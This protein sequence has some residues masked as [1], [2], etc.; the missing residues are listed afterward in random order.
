MQQPTIAVL[1]VQKRRRQ[2]LFGLAGA[3]PV[4]LL[5]TTLLPAAAQAPV[6]PVGVGKA[7]RVAVIDVA[8]WAL[9]DQ[10]GRAGGVFIDLARQLAQASGVGLELLV[11]PYPR[12]IA[13]LAASDAD[14]MFSVGGDALQRVALPVA[15]LADDD[16]ILIARAGERLQSLADLRGKTVGHVRG[17]EYDA[18]FSADPAIIKYATSNYEQDVRMLL[19]KRIDA[20]I[21]VRTGLQYAARLQGADR[22]SLQALLLRRTQ[23]SLYLARRHADPRL[24]EQLRAAC[25]MLYQRQAMRQL[26][27]LYCGA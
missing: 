2:L 22:G 15:T 10:H 5:P 16:I 6:G 25:A 14:I 18:A 8:P 20:A 4:N 9:R 23:I 11:V 24:A 1:N 27:R 12:A 21:G 7:L 26:V 17:A 19:L 3:L 13:M